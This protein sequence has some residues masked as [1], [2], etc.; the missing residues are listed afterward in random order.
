LETNF[1]LSNSLGTAEQRSLFLISN[2]AHRDVNN[3][4]KQCIILI[5][6]WLAIGEGLEPALRAAVGVRAA[7]SAGTVRRD[8]ALQGSLPASH[9]PARSASL[10][11]AKVS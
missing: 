9:Q 1:E 11:L 4:V 3:Y 5:A 7:A 8:E 6:P 10:A 2:A